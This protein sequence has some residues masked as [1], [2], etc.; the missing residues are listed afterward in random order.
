M[1]TLFED[2]EHPLYLLIHG[3][4]LS[5]LQTSMSPVVKANISFSAKKDSLSPSNIPGKIFGSSKKKFLYFHNLP[6]LM[7]LFN[8]VYHKIF[9]LKKKKR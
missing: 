2:E 3:N 5:L 9:Y 4:P 6:I 7:D 8:Y 1:G